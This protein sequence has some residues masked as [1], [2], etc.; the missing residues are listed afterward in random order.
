MLRGT[1]ALS[2]A[3]SGDRGNWP[4]PPK[5]QPTRGSRQ[6]LGAK[7]PWGLSTTDSASEEEEEEE[8]LQVG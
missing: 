8:A 6:W 1:T 7:D 2:A 5:S 3:P 4:V